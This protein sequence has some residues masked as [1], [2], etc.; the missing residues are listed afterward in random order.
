MSVDQ[1]SPAAYSHKSMWARSRGVAAL[2]MLIAATVVF[3]QGMPV[4]AAV[5]N[6]LTASVTGSGSVTVAWNRP[7]GSLA[8]DYAYTVYFR[9]GSSGGYTLRDVNAGTTSAVLSGL[10]GGRAYEIRV[11]ASPTRST[12][13]DQTNVGREGC[14]VDPATP[15]DDPTDAPSTSVTAATAPAA[16]SVT[17]VSEGNGQISV[18]FTAGATNGAT[19]S[20]Y[21]ATCGALTAEGASSP[22]VV[23]GLTN[24]VS[25]TC[26][27][28]AGSNVG[29][30][31]SSAA[32]ESVTP[33]TTPDRM[34][35]PTVSAGD[36]NVSVSW[37][38]VS[39]T[40][41]IGGADPTLV[42]DGGSALTGHTIRIVRADN[43][44]EVSTTAAA[45]G[46]TS[47][48]ITGLTNGTAYRA[49]VLA[50]NGNGSGTYSALSESFTPSAGA[51]VTPALSISTPP[52]A[53]TSGTA[54]SGGA[55]PV[56]SAG[57]GLAGVIVTVAVASGDATLSGALTATSAGT[58]LATFTNLIVVRASTG[59]VTLR[60]TASGYTSA[61]SSAFTVTVPGG[62]T[63]GGGA[64]TT[65]STTV[66]RSVTTT[67][68]RRGVTTTT[69]TTPTTVTTTTPTTVRTATAIVVPRRLG[70]EISNLTQPAARVAND[71]TV[72]V[73]DR[74]LT[75]LVIPPTLGATRVARYIVTVRPVGGGRAVSRT[76][77]VRGS[78]VLTQSFGNLRGRYR[79]S[80]SAVNRTGKVIGSWRT[81]AITVR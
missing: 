77:S 9:E 71:A 81:K 49:Q 54:F 76:L 19:I 16:P 79:V 75:V 10:N 39:S 28:I 20:Q 60:F 21:T 58:G 14:Y 33:S 22:L 42:D 1:Y 32:S 68:L 40:S 59:N 29:D 69:T 51:G 50:S 65:T 37:P 61:T 18:S 48:T 30:S 27:V 35:P 26:T 2:A 7:A 73:R 15:C 36:T 66:P 45:A 63:S 57:E 47:A 55:R 56:I 70:V 31:P 44:N 5:V 62:G 11:T 64:V 43:S 4:S 74:T 46:A 8:N 78:K 80:V 17:S 67:T 12:T 34:D 41:V 38:A 6:S 23:T 52:G 72:A 53:V 3:A 13:G 25:R 24:G